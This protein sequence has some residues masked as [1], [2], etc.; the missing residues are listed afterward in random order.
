MREGGLMQMGR[1]GSRQRPLPR[2]SVS[3]LPLSLLLVSNKL[4]FQAGAGD[5]SE[6]TESELYT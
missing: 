5:V 4:L 2:S 6:V 1:E 3:I